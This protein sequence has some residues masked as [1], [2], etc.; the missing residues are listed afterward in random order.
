MAGYLI[1]F[2]YLVGAISEPLYRRNKRS[3]GVGRH[4]GIPRS[5]SSIWSYGSLPLSHAYLSRSKLFQLFRTTRS[6]RLSRS[7][8]CIIEPRG[9]FS[10]SLVAPFPARSQTP[11]RISFREEIFGEVQVR[12]NPADPPMSA[13]LS[14]ALDPSYPETSYRKY[15]RSRGI[16]EG[17]RRTP[18]ECIFD[19]VCVV[20]ARVHAKLRNSMHVS[21]H[22]GHAA[23]SLRLS[24]YLAS[25][26]VARAG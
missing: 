2:T 23:E 15:K 22:G 20:R 10:V 5:R 4:T 13:S 9:N 3:R 25:G 21:F 1:P 6:R 18:S 8:N 24:F 14:A 16:R 19:P 17:L 12:G 26:I 7:K 11:R